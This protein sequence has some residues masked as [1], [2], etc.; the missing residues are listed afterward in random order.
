MDC[1]AKLALRV[2]TLLF[3]DNLCR[4]PASS[5]HA[6][7]QRRSQAV[8]AGDCAALGLPLLCDRSIPM[9]SMAYSL[10]VRP[11]GA[12][13]CTENIFDSIKQFFL[14]PPKRDAYRLGQSD[15]RGRF[16]EI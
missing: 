1:T 10:Q 9:F 11:D 8:T 4:T 14:P 2:F 12:V 15:W 16:A 7:K 3:F 13:L 5:L 6:F